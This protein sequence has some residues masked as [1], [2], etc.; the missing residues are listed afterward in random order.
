MLHKCSLTCRSV[1]ACIYREPGTAELDTDVGCT[2]HRRSDRLQYSRWSTLSNIASSKVSKNVRHA[3]RWLSVMHLILCVRIPCWLVDRWK[4]HMECTRLPLLCPSSLLTIS[5][6]R[7]PSPFW[8]IALSSEP[9][10]ISIE[11]ALSSVVKLMQ[12]LRLAFAVVKDLHW[13]HELYKGHCIKQECSTYQRLDHLHTGISTYCPLPQYH[14]FL[15]RCL[16]KG[17][18][19]LRSCSVQQ[20]RSSRPSAAY[21]KEPIQKA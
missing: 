15:A 1:L 5:C 3:K 4:V 6:N 21:F 19:S 11:L 8:P 17:C 7:L 10:N 2:L 18:N 16:G 14:Y 12:N 13:Y 9:Q 20:S